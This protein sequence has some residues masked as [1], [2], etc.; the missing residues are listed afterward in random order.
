M[1]DEKTVE[2]KPV[3]VSADVRKAL[4]VEMMAGVI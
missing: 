2:S 4:T 3:G 1:R